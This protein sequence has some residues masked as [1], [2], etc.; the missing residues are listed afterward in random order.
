MLVHR[1]TRASNAGVTRDP[2]QVYTFFTDPNPIAAMPS[3]HQA[4]TLLMALVLWRERRWLGVLGGLYAL[5]MGASLVYLGE[6]YLVDVLAG[7]AL[8]AGVCVL[9]QRRSSSAG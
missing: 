6:H 3:L 4:F 1:I 2:E 8:A 7:A 9:L 5:A